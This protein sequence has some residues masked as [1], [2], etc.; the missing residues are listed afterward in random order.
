MNSQCIWAEVDLGAIAHNMKEIRRVTHP[1]ARLMAIVK[2]NA[3]GHGAVP[4]SKTVV[5]NG[6][7][8]LGVARIA[9]AVELRQAGIHVP[10][11]VLGYV[12]FNC[13]KDLWEFDISTTVYSASMARAMSRAASRAGKN[14]RMH[15]KVDT[16]MGRLG[17]LLPFLAMPDASRKLDAATAEAVSIIRLPGLELE[18]V[19]THFAAA[20]MADKT[21]SRRQFDSFMAFLNM[22]EIQGV[23]IPLRHAANTAAIIELPETHLDLVRPGIGIYGYY[24]SDEVRRGVLSLRPAMT[25]KTRIIYLK[26]VPAGFKVSYGMTYETKKP[27]TIA[28]VASGYAD[29]VNRLLSNSGCMLVHG[30]RA[31][32][33]GRI[34]MDQTMLDV[35]HVPHV[36]L[37]DEAVV[38]GRQGESLMG[39]D[40]VA[41][42]YHT[43]SYEVV[44]TVGCRV[45]RMYRK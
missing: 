26:Q 24:P 32:V 43:I 19:F 30:C 4:V 40:E 22:L 31:P 34:C 8:M 13:L 3:Y 1:G 42:V 44:S 20:D 18:G 9:E 39:A 37:E 21:F 36:A 33:V 12:P 23:E 14:I 29:G 25:L 41:A 15:L 27:T 45:P 5:E 11:V 17:L 10:I 7:E 35:G 16:G 2:A 6:A 28:T 38:F